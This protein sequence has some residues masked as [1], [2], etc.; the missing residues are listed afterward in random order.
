MIQ[1]L[2]ATIED[3]NDIARCTRLAYADE[4]HG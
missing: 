3:A 2:N 1:V 4:C